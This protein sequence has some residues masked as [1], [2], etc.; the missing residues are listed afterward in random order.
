M[1]MEV[2]CGPYLGLAGWRDG[3]AAF[4]KAFSSEAGAGRL[5]LVFGSGL[6]IFEGNKP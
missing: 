3:L 6:G 2:S 5:V 1:Y 4:R